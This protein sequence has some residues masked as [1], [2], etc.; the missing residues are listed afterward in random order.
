MIDDVW[1]GGKASDGLYPLMSSAIAAGLYHVNCK[2]TH[3]TFFPGISDAPDD[4]WTPAELE[5]V[6]MFN[7]TEAR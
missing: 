1:S 5:N 2:D 4:T 6:Q 7:E 3:T